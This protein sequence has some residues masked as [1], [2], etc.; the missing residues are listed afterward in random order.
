MHRRE[1]RSAR[2]LGDI[3]R[4]RSSNP[5]PTPLLALPPSI[6]HTCLPLRQAGRHHTGMSRLR[7]PKDAWL[8]LL[9][10]DRLGRRGAAACVS[11]PEP[12]SRCD[13]KAVSLVRRGRHDSLAGG[14]IGHAQLG[15]GHSPAAADRAPAAGQVSVSGAKQPSHQSHLTSRRV[16]LLITAR[17]SGI[18][19]PAPHAPPAPARADHAR[20]SRASAAPRRA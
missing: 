11:R 19:P 1:R 17:N 5:T 9:D 8:G 4:A 15:G 16:K 6:R 7:D 3:G 2:P 18:D 14:V 13:A 20:E 12:A 10:A